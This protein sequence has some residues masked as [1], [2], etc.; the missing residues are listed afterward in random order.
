ML[1]HPLCVLTDGSQ[2]QSSLS[3]TAFGQHRSTELLQQLLL[4][5][6]DRRVAHFKFKYLQLS[7][8]LYFV[9]LFQPMAFTLI[10][11]K[12]ARQPPILT[13]QFCGNPSS[14]FPKQATQ[15]FLIKLSKYNILTLKENKLEK[16]KKP[17]NTRLF[18]I[19]DVRQRARNKI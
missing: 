13:L 17:C 1:V 5:A 15:K 4:N 10:K 3:H 19:E 12:F 16:L 6:S 9:I 2:P 8:S 18:I 14:N 11:T 7:N